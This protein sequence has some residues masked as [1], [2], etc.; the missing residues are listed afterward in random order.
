MNNPMTP[1]DE[2]DF[3]KSTRDETQRKYDQEKRETQELATKL[4]KKWLEIKGIRNEKGF[5][6]TNVRL[7]VHKQRHTEDFDFNLL[8]EEPSSKMFNG[9]AL[10]G[11]EVSRRNKSMKIRA[12]VR[13]I[14]NGKYV[15]RTRKAFVKWPN[16][17]IEI[18]EQFQVHVFTMPS[19]IQLEI[20]IGTAYGER[21][22]DV[23][24]VEVPGKYV[25]ALTSASSLVKELPFSK[26]AYDERKLAKKYMSQTKIDG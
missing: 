12:Y 24:D 20:V 18:M 11:R 23:L 25:K 1:Q 6:A 22:A 2:L 9:S 15:S 13:L 14:I 17:E 3:L 4:Y 19:S 26:F 16:F 10:T 5:S 7:K 21:L 8:P